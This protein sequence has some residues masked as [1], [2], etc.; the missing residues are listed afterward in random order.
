MRPN[1]LPV[2]REVRRTGATSLHEIT[3]ALNAP[4]ITTPRGGAVVCV[5][6]TECVGPSVL[7][8]LRCGLL[9]LR[10]ETNTLI[11]DCVKAASL[12]FAEIEPA[13]AGKSAGTDQRD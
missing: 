11:H 13:T 8:L 10:A 7:P 9:P 5:V 3:N 1:V 12:N 4:G 2:I 6:R